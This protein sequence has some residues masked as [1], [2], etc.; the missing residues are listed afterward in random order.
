MISSINTNSLS[1]LYRS[2]GQ[3]Y[4]TLASKIASGKEISKPSDDFVGYTRANAIQQD[5]SGYETVNVNLTELKEV[6]QMA[7]DTG[8]GMYDDLSR[9]KELADVYA[10]GSAE[11]QAAY[12]SEFDALSTTLTNTLADSQYG[13]TAIVANGTIKSADLDP[14]GN[15]TF[16]IEYVT[17]EDIITVANL[18]ITDASTVQTELELATSYTVKSEGYLSQIDR[19]IGINETLISNKEA[20]SSAITDIDEIKAL[21]QAT[22]LQVRQQASVSMIAQANMMSGGVARLY[23]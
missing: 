8:N 13:G 17:A 6:A 22:E 3:E 18:D 12:Q 16:D 11:E 20:T 7:S 2:Q 9:M 10:S 1:Q 19:H 5:I 23:S 15:S 21:Q 14:D 4:S